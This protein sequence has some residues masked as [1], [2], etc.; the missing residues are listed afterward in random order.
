MGGRNPL[1][2]ANVREQ[3][4]LIPKPSA[5]PNSP[6]ESIWKSKSLSIRSGQVFQQ[7][8]RA[9]WFG[10]WGLQLV[11]LGFTPADIFDIPHSGKPGGLAWF[12][13]GS[14]VMA[15]GPSFAKLQDGRMCRKTGA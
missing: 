3:R 11:T 12:M 15:L 13:R 2:W 4:A 1:F 8:V 14:P 9:A 10:T 7:T 6:A 5:H